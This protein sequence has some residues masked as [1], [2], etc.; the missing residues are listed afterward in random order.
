MKLRLLLLL[1]A[2][3]FA[4]GCSSE[5]PAPKADSAA[6]TAAAPAAVPAAPTMAAPSPREPAAAPPKAG[7]A[8]PGAARRCGWLHNPTPGNWWLVDRDGEWIL[9]AQGGYQA[10][11]MDEM[12]DMSAL[13][14]EK[15]NGHYGHGCA[16]LTLMS[17]PSTRQVT[18]VSDATPLPLAQ[19]R[20]D[21]ALPRP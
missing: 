14:W 2:F 20:A 3:A 16:C 15:T 8:P 13:E 4:A 19:C 7:A 12:P 21:R 10:P 6:N 1:A 5:P 9:G 17:D 18:R 11:G